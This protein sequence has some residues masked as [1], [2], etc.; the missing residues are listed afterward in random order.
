M[1][2]R[3]Q[4]RDVAQFL[5][6]IRDFLLGR[7]HKTAHRF[8]DTMSPRTQPQPHIPSGPFRRLFGNYYYTRDP[9]RSVKPD[10]D[11]VQERMNMIA[12][13]AKAKAAAQAA[14]KAA[15]AQ[16]GVKPPPAQPAVKP[17]PPPAP[18]KAADAKKADECDEQKTDSGFKNLP[19]PGKMHSWEGPS[20]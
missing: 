9:R 17:P 14:A 19:T 6:K 7:K 1:P 3:P 10:I 16:P 5:S 11:V 20:D 8:A 18:P 4:H 2:P 15:P 12:A 13:K